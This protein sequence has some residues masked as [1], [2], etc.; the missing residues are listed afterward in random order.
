MENLIRI[1]IVVAVI[2]PIY[3]LKVRRNS[4]KRIELKEI[5]FEELE[6][7][8]GNKGFYWFDLMTLT[9]DKESFLNGFNERT[10]SI[11]KVN[12][13]NHLIISSD[14]GKYVDNSKI[15]DSRKCSKFTPLSE[16]ESEKFYT[17]QAAD[18]YEFTGTVKGIYHSD[19]DYL[20]IETSWGD[21]ILCS[22]EEGRGVIF[23]EVIR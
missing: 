11:Q 13:Y 18:P 6:K 17:F 19:G 15:V 10:F 1:V 21:F 14:P 22:I 4:N 12:K 7:M 9:K 16:F 20:V 8:K 5:S 23:L 3:F 2:A